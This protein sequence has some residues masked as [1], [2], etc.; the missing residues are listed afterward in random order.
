MTTASDN[1]TKLAENLRNQRTQFSQLVKIL[2]IKQAEFM[3]SPWEDYF[4]IRRKFFAR[5]YF[6]IT[7]FL[8]IALA[9]VEELI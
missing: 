8:A 1:P 5:I 4:F 9:I 6:R 2:M 7:P 3:S